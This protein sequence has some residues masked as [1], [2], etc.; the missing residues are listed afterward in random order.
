LSRNPAGFT[1]LEVLLAMA[2]VGVAILGLLG[3]YVS[4]LK[5]VAQQRDRTTAVDL[6]RRTLEGIKAVPWS[7]LPADDADFEGGPR[8]GA[9]PPSPYPGEGQFRVLVKVVA[10]D[11][12]LRTVTVRVRWGP[13]HEVKLA[14]VLSE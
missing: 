3:V 12:H 4:G 2:L 8:A 10:D 7:E 11:P 9:F 6:A 5:A 13:S 1:L 14:T